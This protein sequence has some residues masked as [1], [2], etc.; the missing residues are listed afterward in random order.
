LR[1]NLKRGLVVKRSEKAKNA[2]TSPKIGGPKMAPEW[3][4]F[5]EKKYEKN[6]EKNEC[7]SQ[8]LLT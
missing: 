8:F 7:G 6:D 2:K 4:L 3:H 1:K 5:H